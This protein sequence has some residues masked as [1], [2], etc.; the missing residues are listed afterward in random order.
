M[1]SRTQAEAGSSTPTD[2]R[3]SRA[4]LQVLFD[5]S[6]MAIGFSRD[7]I[8]LDANPAYVRLFGYGSVEELRGRSILE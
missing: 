3:V 6:P 4:G 2:G 5:E 8:M 7:G 1:S